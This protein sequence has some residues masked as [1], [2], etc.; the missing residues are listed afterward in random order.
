MSID[1]KKCQVFES[2]NIATPKGRLSYA[3]Y[4]IEPQEN[5]NGKLKYNCNIVVP[6]DA[7]LTALKNKMGKIALDKCDGDKNRAKNL[8]EKRFL[9]P[10]NLPGGGKPMGD[11]FDGFVLLRGSSDYKPT[12]V[13]PNGQP[14]P[15]EEIANELY[16]GRW[17]RVSFNPYWSGNKQ[18]PGVFL[19]LQN[20]QLLDHDDN[21][22]MKRVRAEDEF[23]AVD[24]AGG[25][26]TSTSG[27]SD[28]DAMFG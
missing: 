25:A 3:Q 2:G 9:D 28:V 17:A 27:D 22:G 8:V 11:E 10:N 15:D 21:I 14:I 23:T 19:G 6:G 13:Y 1:M 24:D 18:N 20:V 4:L 5:Q 7:D 16:S 12:F 26:E